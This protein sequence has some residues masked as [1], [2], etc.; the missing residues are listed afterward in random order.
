VIRLRGVRALLT[1]IEGTTTAL[2]FVHQQLF[3]YARRELAAYV[4][5]HEPELGD[6][7]A[8]TQAAANAATLSTDALIAQLLRWIDEDRK[9][10]PLKQLQGRIWRSGYE[11]GELRGHVYEDAV[12]RLRTWHAAGIRIYIYSSGSIEAQRLLFSHTTVGD[13][14]PLISGYFD[15]TTGPKLEPQSYHSIAGSLA[16]PGSG[17]VFLSDHPGETAAAAQTGMQSVLLVRG[18]SPVA[19]TQPSA[20]SFDEI[21]LTM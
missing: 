12:Q 19:V 13:L 16:L 10:T 3:P 15:T 5:T 14:T 7:F 4:R 18:D 21:E 6:I 2:E 8:A 9:V 20:R 17:I 11:S 1:D